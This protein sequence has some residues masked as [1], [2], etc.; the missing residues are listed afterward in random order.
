MNIQ[1]KLPETS[2]THICQT[3]SET[4]CCRSVSSTDSFGP[5]DGVYADG[6]CGCNRDE[7]VFDNGVVDGDEDDV[8]D[9]GDDL[10]CH[11][12]YHAA[13]ERKREIGVDLR[14]IAASHE[15]SLFLRMSQP[16]RIR[17]AQP[18]A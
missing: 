9:A 8:G 1:S 15:V 11:P 12:R 4:C 14:P 17:Q 5:D 13:H 3:D 2:D 6:A 7:D 10:D 16:I 18:K